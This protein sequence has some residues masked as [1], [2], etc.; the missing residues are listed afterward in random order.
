[1]YVLYIWAARALMYALA[2]TVALGYPNFVSYLAA[3]AIM[4]LMTPRPKGV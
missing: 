3:G 4:A 2:L 1:M